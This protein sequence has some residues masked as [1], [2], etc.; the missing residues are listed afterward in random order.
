MG[1]RLPSDYG[2]LSG[3][4]AQRPAECQATSRRLM[5]DWE[6]LKPDFKCIR[7]RL[8]NCRLAYSFVSDPANK[9]TDAYLLLLKRACIAPIDKLLRSEV[10]GNTSAWDLRAVM[11]YLEDHDRHLKK[12]MLLIHMDGVELAW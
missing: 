8:S 9:L 4:I 11:K 12:L 6:P 2:C 5:C 10:N 3:A 7:D 1:W